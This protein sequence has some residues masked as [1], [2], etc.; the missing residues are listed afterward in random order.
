MTEST[1]AFYALPSR[2]QRLW[3]WFGFGEAR[4][5]RPDEDELSEGWAPS[6]FIIGTKARLDW[7]DRIRVLISGKVMIEQAVKTDVIIG[8]SRSTSAFSVLRPDA[9]VRR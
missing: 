6:W 5:E 1:Q 2:S 8:R 9:D 3:C 7:K 4:A